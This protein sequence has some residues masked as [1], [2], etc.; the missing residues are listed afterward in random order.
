MKQIIET[1]TTYQHIIDNLDEYIEN[2]LQEGILAFRELHATEQQQRTILA[3]FG[4]KLGWLPNKKYPKTHR[5]LENH[6]NAL[7]V[8][9]NKSKDDLIVLWH[10]E[11]CSVKHSQSAAA[12]NMLRFDCDSSC[13]TTGFIDASKIYED[14]P[15][16][17]QVFLDKCMIRDH[18]YGYLAEEFEETSQF[19]SLDGFTYTSHPRKAVLDHP[20]RRIK[21]CRI[22]PILVPADLISVDGLKPSDDDLSLFSDIWDFY[23]KEIWENPDRAMWWQ[24][25]KGDLIIPDLSVMIHSVRGGFNF[26]EREFVGYWAYYEDAVE[27]FPDLHLI[28]SEKDYIL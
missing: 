16:E 8:Y 23:H 1:H 4:D 10:L 25:K 13:G 5:Y 12:W 6:D 20:T 18:M 9:A 19:K 11:H 27:S 17:W 26:N 24:W 14:M 3:Y 2:F 22:N 7:T 21:V 15:K 28:P